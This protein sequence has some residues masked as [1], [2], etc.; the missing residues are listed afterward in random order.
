VSVTDPCI[1]WK[2]TEALLLRADRDLGEALAGR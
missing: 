2:T 1:D